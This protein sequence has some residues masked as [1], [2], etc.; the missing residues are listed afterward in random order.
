[1]NISKVEVEKAILSVLRWQNDAVRTEWVRRNP[2][3][4]RR[5]DPSHWQTPGNVSGEYV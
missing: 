3:S 2:K 4:R 5:P 1:M